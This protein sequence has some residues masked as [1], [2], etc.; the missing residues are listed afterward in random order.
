MRRTYFA[1]LV[2]QLFFGYALYAQDYT[3]L[4]DQYVSKK[5]DS[6]TY[7]LYQGRG[8]DTTVI[9]PETVSHI[10]LFSYL[11][12]GKKN[13]DHQ[14]DSASFVRFAA[15]Q[16]NT[17]QSLLTVE[18]NGGQ[19]VYDHLTVEEFVNM[20]NLTDMASVIDSSG[21][22]TEYTANTF[23]TAKALTATEKPGGSLNNKLEGKQLEIVLRQN[24][25]K[26]LY[27]DD[28]IAEVY[29][30]GKVQ[31]GV[32]IIIYTKA[33]NGQV[34]ATRYRSNNEGQFFFK[35][36]RSGLWLIQAVYANPSDEE[37]V[38]YNF[39]QSSYSFSFQ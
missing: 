26:M 18:F 29:L 11:Q 24:P 21:F 22:T 35:V 38:D 6:V 23:F 28:I 19:A 13:T 9:A 5:G 16:Q 33:M 20:E 25:Y 31:S 36:N 10:S 30:D 7:V 37:G 27:G 8:L 34:F 3:L 2:F 17:G 15:V 1:C 4:A 32:S 39:Y 14:V 12:G